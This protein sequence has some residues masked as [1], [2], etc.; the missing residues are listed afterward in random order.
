[1]QTFLPYPD[2]HESARCLDYKRLGKQRVEAMQ[3]IEILCD[4]SSSK[5]KAW[6]NHP[7]VH[8][9][10]G[11]EQALIEYACII[12]DEWTLQGFVDN[13]KQKIVQYKNDKVIYPWWLGIS[14]FHE[15]HQSN[16]FRKNQVYYRDFENVGPFL[17]YCWPIIQD[18]NKFL[19]YKYSSRPG[20]EIELYKE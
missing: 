10:R 19:R 18:G 9:W 15:S 4:K 12:C 20:Y 7:V 2:F 16:L 11:Y 8:M 6:V 17:P 3:V 13:C 1:M 14:K 5:P